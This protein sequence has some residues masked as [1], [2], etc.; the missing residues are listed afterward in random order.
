MPIDRN[1][2][3]YITGAIYKPTQTS[4]P[5]VWD[6]DDQANNLAKNLWPLPPNVIQRSLRF[7]SADSAYL[8]RTPATAGNRT[9]WTWSA[10]VKRGGLYTTNAGP[11]LF[12]AGPDNGNFSFVRFLSDNQD[13]LD[14]GWVISGSVVSV[15]RSNAFYRDPS[16]W[17]HIVAVL[18]TTN[19]TTSDR[20]RLYVNGQ[21]ITSF[22]TTTYPAQN[23]A[24]CHINATNVHYLGRSVEPL[25]RYMD[26]YMA[27]VNF[28]DGQALTPT[29]FGETDQQTGAWIPKRYVGTYG[30]N[31]FRLSFANNS[32]ITALGYDSSGQGNNWTPNNFS[33]TPGVGNDVFV[34]VPSLYGT[35]TGLG[36]E[37]L[38]NY[39]TLNSLA[40]GS[41][42]S[43]SNGAL[44]IT[45][46]TATNSGGSLATIG[47][48][49]GKWYFEFTV[50]STTS[51]FG[52][53]VTYYTNNAV[54]NDENNVYGS[55][56]SNKGIG[57]RGS[58]STYGNAAEKQTIAAFTY[59]TS[60]IIGV[61]IDADNGAV[62]FR[63]NNTWLNSGV[64]T[65]G[66]SRTGSFHNWTPAADRV[67]YPALV[68][69]NGQAAT[70]NFGQRPFT[71]AAP[72]G[73]KALCTTNL[74]A[75]AIGQTAA[76]QADNHFNVVTY[77]GNG[78]AQTITGVGFQPDLVWVKN[79]TGTQWHNFTDSVRGTN[80]QLYSNDTAV[81]GTASNALT[82]FNP[83]GFSV[84]SA[85]DW[86]GNG[87]SMVA[88]CWNAGGVSV[89]NNAGTNNAS[90]ASTYRAN[91]A[92][93]FSIVTYTGNS[94][95]GATVSHGL[96]VAPSM[97]ILK[98]R[99]SA[100]GWAVYHT[101]LGPTQYIWMMQ[102]TG[103]ATYSGA[104]NN[105]AP[106]NSVFT[107][108][109]DGQWNGAFN[110]VAYCW[111]EIPGYSAFGKYD[112][113][114]N[115]N[116]FIYTGFKPAFV[117]I[118]SYSGAYDQAYASWT[119]YDNKRN[120]TNKATNP[121]FANLSA[122]EGARGNG[123]SQPNVLDIDLLSNGFKILVNATEINYG[124]YVYAAFAE[125]PARLSTAR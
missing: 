14:F 3:Q 4:A 116:P 106:T 95:A 100:G 69:Y 65:S 81:Q 11:T 86:N 121:L 109:S 75:P 102:T 39:C 84:G 51:S 36:G 70:A 35:D 101:S 77:T 61:A 56:G 120:P 20:M 92:A 83:D 38:G 59:G 17:Y 66:A 68:A 97:I 21:R 26:D 50:T 112:A 73:F 48:A 30:T 24:T 119:I 44:D 99:T 113:G 82:S 96:G 110:Y 80:S 115:S 34:D 88:W 40:L 67:C 89:T 108:G 5:G 8:N 125:T 85:G 19:A 60:D 25:Y 13:K 43:L 45:G 78:T 118:K 41:Y 28:V 90:V 47:V 79:R 62:Y 6:L 22:L 111:A 103:A 124:L 57:I 49:T 9:T 2:A 63:V 23:T 33:I 46:T 105:T 87:Y 122:A 64:P 32:S 12:D 98:S 76:N 72:S 114:S 117:M 104:W 123:S 42:A 18:D 55:S 15:I 53:V 37:V 16:A 7:N 58:G 91:R 27:E 74:P 1:S 94:T 71:Y 107:L 31:G 93:G 29:S 10:W 52:G 54:L